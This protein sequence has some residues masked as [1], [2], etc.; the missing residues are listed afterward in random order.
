[1]RSTCAGMCTDPCTWCRCNNYNVHVTKENYIQWVHA[2]CSMC[3]HPPMKISTTSNV[4]AKNPST[5]HPIYCK[6]CEN[7]CRR[8]T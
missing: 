5:N 2:C 1:M 6:A 4:S 8:T 7:T 3:E